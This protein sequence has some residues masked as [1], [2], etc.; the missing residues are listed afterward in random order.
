[1]R[2]GVLPPRR[3]ANAVEAPGNRRDRVRDKNVHVPT[4]GDQGRGGGGRAAGR[5]DRGTRRR[6]GAV[7]GARGVGEAGARVP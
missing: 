6:H 3:A 7:Q 5:G 1:M 2:R 4:F